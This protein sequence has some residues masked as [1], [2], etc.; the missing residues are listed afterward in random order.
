MDIDRDAIKLIGL[1]EIVT[2]RL[3]VDNRT[4]LWA[5]NIEAMEWIPRAG[6]FAFQMN[7]NILGAGFNDAVDERIANQRTAIDGL[8][9]HLKIHCPKLM[10]T[11]ECDQIGKH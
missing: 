1:N 10:G 11:G 6:K 5:T 4:A 9:E 8:L 3:T 2:V 7:G